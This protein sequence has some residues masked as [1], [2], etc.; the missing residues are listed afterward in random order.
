MTDPIAHFASKLPADPSL[1]SPTDAEDR[2][3]LAALASYPVTWVDEHGVEHNTWSRNHFSEE[4]EPDLD[5]DP[6]Y[7]TT[8]PEG[9][10]GLG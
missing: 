10:D 9:H 5:G 6:L 2:T 1:D 8:P 7:T 3:A 4:I